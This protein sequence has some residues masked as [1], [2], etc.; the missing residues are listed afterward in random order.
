M[1]KKSFSFL[2]AAFV[3]LLAS[4]ATKQ[5]ISE[6]TA[7]PSELKLCKNLRPVYVTNSKKIYLLAP[8]YSDKVIDALQLLDGS[9]GKTKFALM[10]YSQIDTKGISLSL[11]NDFGAD[12][13]NLSFNGNAVSFNSAYFPSALPAEYIINDIQNAFYEFDSLS[14]NYANSRL[15]FEEAEGAG[16]NGSQIK[17]RKIYDGKKL[18]EEIQFLENTVAIK[19]YLRGYEYNLTEVEE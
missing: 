12:M 18:I 2:I 15:H 17:I 1:M 10:S 6:N 14:L 7:D 8:E 16:E 19:N 13:G 5:A 9:F 4:C 3:L 11:F